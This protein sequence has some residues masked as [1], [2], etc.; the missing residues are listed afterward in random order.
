MNYQHKFAADS[1]VYLRVKV[2]LSDHKAISGYVVKVIDHRFLILEY[3][4]WLFFKRNTLIDIN[5]IE[6]VCTMP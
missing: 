6:D 3:K 1:L 5:R 2:T 4:K